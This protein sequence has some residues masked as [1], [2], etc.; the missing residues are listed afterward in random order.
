ME[1]RQLVIGGGG[2]G[3]HDEVAIL[4]QKHQWKRLSI[5]SFLNIYDVVSFAASPPNEKEPEVNN[6]MKGLFTVQLNC[7]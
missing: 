7:T 5:K 4:I 2:G 6:L 3:E 1:Q